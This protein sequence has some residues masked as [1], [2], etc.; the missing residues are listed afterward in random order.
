MLQGKSVAKL[1]WERKT[2]TEAKYMMCIKLNTK[3]GDMRSGYIFPE[4]NFL[5]AFQLMEIPLPVS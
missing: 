3:M 2:Q 5:L 4:E 1:C